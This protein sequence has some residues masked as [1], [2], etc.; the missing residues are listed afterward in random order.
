MRAAPGQYG[1]VGANGGIL[2]KYSVGVY[3]TTPTPWQADH[4]AQLQADIDARPLEAVTENA[5]GRGTVEAY[6]VRRDNGR[7]TGI[8]IGRLDADNSRFLATTEEDDSVAL[9]TEGEPLGQSVTVRSFDYGNR[10][11]LR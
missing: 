10:C 3:T 5:A 9:L 11:S 8:V 7:L 2:S 4:S 1:L 6:T